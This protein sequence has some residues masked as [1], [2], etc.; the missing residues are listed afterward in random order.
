M[1]PVL[2]EIGEFLM[3]FGVGAD[4][5]PPGRGSGRYPK[6][7]GENP[8]QHGNANFLERVKQLKK[9]GFI[10]TDPETGRKYSG[11]TAIAKYFKMS[12]SDFQALKNRLKTEER[13][14][15]VAQAVALREEGKSLM[16]IARIMGYKNDS[17]VRAL[18]NEDTNRKRNAISETI[19]ILQSEVDKHKIID[20]GD[21]VERELGISKERLKEAVSSLKLDGYQEFTYY[22]PQINNKGKFTTRKVLCTEDIEESYLKNPANFDKVHLIQED[23]VS[24]DGGETFD[25][26]WVYP[27]SMDSK[28]L[29]VV[30][31]DE[32]GSDK[33]G[34]I[35]IR[36]GVDDLSLGNS[37][38]AQVRILVDGT[39]YI[40]GMAVYKDDMPNGVDVIFNTN[41]PSGTPVCGADKSHS[42]LKL[43]SKDSDNPFGSLIKDGI[44]DPH[45]P[46][47]QKGG[48]S[49]YYDKNGD[50]HLSL[51]N[52]R[53]EEGDW[54]DWAD[55]LPA[56]FL[57]KQSK[58]LIKSQLDISY[59]DKLAEYED[60]RQLDNPTIKKA[61]LKSFADDCDTSAVHLKAA[62]LPRQK[63]QVIIPLT[64]IKDNEVYAPQ[65]TDG[66]TVALVRY[67]HGGT[68][69]IPILKVN[70]K[71]KEGNKVLGK[72][73]KDAVGINSRVAARLSG[74]DFDGDTV[75]VIPCNNPDS[76][77]HIISTHPLKG[78]EGF[79]P[80]LKYG[81]EPDKSGKYP[82]KLMT[83][84]QLEMGII[85]NLI[86]DMTLKGATEDKLV[87]AVRHS[88]VVI[89]AEK[90]CLDYKKSEKDNDIASLKREYQK[91]V[92][93]DGKTKYG[94]AST[95]ISLASS[96]LHVPKRQGEPKINEDG[97]LSYKLADDLYYEKRKKVKKK[98][99]NGRY[100]K[101]ENGEYIYE[102]Y[103]DPKTG[104][105]KIKYENTGK[106]IMRTEK[107]TK[108]AATNDALTL[109]SGTVQ[110]NLYGNYAN[111]MK[112]LANTARKEMISTGNL[113]YNASAKKAYEPQVA[114]LK[115]KLNISEKNAPLERQ[116]QAVANS[117]MNAKRSANKLTKSEDK[118][119]GQQA[120]NQARQ[121]LG[122]HRTAIDISDKEWEAIQA[123]AVSENLLNHIIKYADMDIL[124]ERATPRN[125]NELSA[126]KISRIKSLAARGYTI[127]QIA[128]AVGTSSSTVSKYL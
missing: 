125:R 26:R 42:V 106:I 68:F 36:R 119:L 118:K 9:E 71:Q 86:T 104:K 6:G 112:A 121:K 91:S 3:H 114:S 93:L 10:Y 28:R 59:K 96:E 75:M 31:G 8:F 79:D 54:G 44:A 111:Q 127:E 48:Q 58:K 88:M 82:Y 85:S 98:D 16:E 52:K 64:S 37:S 38:Y 7:S 14:K 63:W 4:D 18:L 115:S 102:T 11:D 32:G 87:R 113:K 76:K 20:V 70:N 17:S 72:L 124:K 120:L 65:Y 25:P 94:G 105:T 23:Y 21:G 53:A 81:G 90:H 74:A 78:L 46:D 122:A 35:E 66:E 41:K 49:Y 57:A 107:T 110:E 39:H 84:T 34:L 109:S 60:I 126:T 77:I 56:Q 67:P 30:Y 97:S 61:L 13:N 128:K 89:D 15:K 103:V 108:M 99:P 47:K 62:A 27:E 29:K 101:D 73:P 83:N 69:E 43:I 92:G 5:N 55:K 12:R 19:D 1:N 80:K 100:L 95:L 33:D 22:I 50:R 45:D 51:I 24:H 117:V 123:G 116:A 2:K 40:K